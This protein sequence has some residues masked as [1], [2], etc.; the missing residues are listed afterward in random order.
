MKS[1]YIATAS[2]DEFV[3]FL[4]VLLRSILDHVTDHFSYTIFIFSDGIRSSRQR[5]I[6]NMASK[7]PNVFIEFIDKFQ[8]LQNNN[9]YARAQITR[10]T[11]SRLFILDLPDYVDKIIYLDADIVVNVDPAD[12]FNVDLSTNYLAA[13]RDPMMTSWC[14]GKQ[15]ESEIK[16]LEQL[17]ISECKDY[18]NAGVM[19]IDLALWR[20]SYSTDYFLNVAI[21]KEWLWFDQDV[22]NKEFYGRVLYLDQTWNF[23]TCT[24]DKHR[25]LLFDRLGYPYREHSIPKI[26]HYAGHTIP[27]YRPR[28][29]NSKYF[30][31]YALHTPY[32]GEILV[33]LKKHLANKVIGIFLRADGKTRDL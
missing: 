10:T 16:N 23:M 28:V 2:S 9:L 7:K 15:R 19:L 3:P 29:I 27:C 22:L 31:K 13:V 4:C 32:F 20:K 17:G 6:E 30:W 21:S 5:E 11:Y 12:L 14:I 25:A 18:F 1:V 24:E 8:Y 33:H 26:I